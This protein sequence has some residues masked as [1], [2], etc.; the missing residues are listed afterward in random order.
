MQFASLYVPMNYEQIAT[1]I[2]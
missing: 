2:V 1:D